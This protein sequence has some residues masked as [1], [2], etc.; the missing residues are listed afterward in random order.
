MR[1]ISV[2]IPLLFA[3]LLP[4]AARER[5]LSCEITP[6]PQDHITESDTWDFS[7]Q[8]ILSDDSPTVMTLHG[9]SLLSESLPDL[10]HWFGIRGDSLLEFG[11]ETRSYMIYPDTL[12]QAF[13]FPLSAG[14]AVTDSYRGSGRIYSRYPMAEHGTYITEVG[15]TGKLILAPG[16]TIGNVTVTRQSRSVLRGINLAA[17]AIDSLPADSL[18]SYGITFYRWYAPGDPLPLAI[19]KSVSTAGVDVVRAF[20]IDPADISQRPAKSGTDTDISPA[21]L[22]EILAAASVTVTD[23]EVNVAVNLPEDL[24]LTVCT[25]V[26]DLQGNLYLHRETEC[27]GEAVITMPTTGL[28]P[29]EYLV[30]ISTPM[31]PDHLEKRYIHIR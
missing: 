8:R 26:V 24:S 23:R 12:T 1:H 27:S 22:A 5:N 18:E 4:A 28:N 6:I 2:I 19:M 17:S 29:G 15:K 21:Q 30:A 13:C 20:M 31:L 14:D 25:D 7:F 16:D 11:E 10:Q 3:A 9:D